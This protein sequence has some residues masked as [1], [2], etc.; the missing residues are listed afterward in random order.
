MIEKNLRNLVPTEAPLLTVRVVP[1]R[2]VVASLSVT[3]NM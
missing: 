3:T 2:V 1:W